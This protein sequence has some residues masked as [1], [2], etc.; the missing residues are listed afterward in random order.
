MTDTTYTNT[1]LSTARRCLREF[2]LRY[3]QRLE[4]DRE[5]REV[6]QVGQAWHRA[7]NSDN[8]PHV[9]SPFDAITEHAPSVLWAEKLRRLYAAY[10]W[11]WQSQDFRVVES[12]HTFYVVLNG[13][14]YEGQIDGIIELED[15]R[16]GILERKTTG[17]GL[18]AGSF[19]WDRLRLDV[20]VGL[21][22]LAV[23]PRPS[24]ILYDVVRKP[25][26][27]PKLISKKDAQ[28]M[29]FELNKKG[30]A[31]YFEE[32][33]ADVVE[34]ALAS[35]REN[36]ELY[37]ARLTAD[38]GE[39]PDFYFA[40]REVPRTSDDYDQ[41]LRDLDQQV[42]VIEYAREKESLHRN[43]DA[44]NAF[45]KCDFFGLCS[46]NIHPSGVGEP[47]DGYRRRERLHPEL[48]EPKETE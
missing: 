32:F 16:R 4:L 15:G 39:R 22:S 3:D 41:L 17:F 9:L 46:S 36:A 44:C 26:I 37:G 5:D 27:L 1:S 10:H 42:R 48:A 40:R 30:T 38:I 18:E 47:P 25:T 19:Y 28:R 29:R 31:T 14:T 20:Q 13:I 23:H 45:G 34:V 2:E 11:Y 7:F 24:F 8:D 21:Y 6:L 12:E 33:H 43:P 35:G